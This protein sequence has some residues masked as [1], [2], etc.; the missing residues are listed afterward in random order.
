MHSVALPTHIL[1]Y[2]FNNNS[3][4]VRLA[5]FNFNGFNNNDVN[6]GSCLV[7]IGHEPIG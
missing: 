7:I 1:V 4:L 2:S 3:I 5:H 6:I